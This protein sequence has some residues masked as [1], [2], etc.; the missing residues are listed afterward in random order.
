MLFKSNRI[1]F[2][3]AFIVPIMVIAQNVEVINKKGTLVTVKNNTVTT[4]S[5]A[6]ADPVEN[7]V[8]LDSSDSENTRPKV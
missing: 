3:F 8:W 5:T 6:P 2:L 4:S 1:A 7:D